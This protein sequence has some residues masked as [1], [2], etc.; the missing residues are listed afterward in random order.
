[1]PDGC[2]AGLSVPSAR[3]PARPPA[4]CPAQVE[5]EL[6]GR[7]PESI[8]AIVELR[9]PLLDDPIVSLLPELVQTLLLS[10]DQLLNDSM[11]GLDQSPVTGEK[12]GSNNTVF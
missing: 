7:L 8:Q 2:L 5:A 1:M 3:P 11:G 4:L 12:G 9:L 6:R 10:L